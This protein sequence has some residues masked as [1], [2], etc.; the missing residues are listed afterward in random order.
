MTE[1]SAWADFLSP[2]EAT[3]AENFIPVAGLK[4]ANKWLYFCLFYFLNATTVSQ[5]SNNRHEQHFKF[6]EEAE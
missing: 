4:T 5:K 6:F 1:I 3:R 2:V